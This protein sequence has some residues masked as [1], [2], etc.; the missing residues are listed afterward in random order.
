MHKVSKM[1]VFACVSAH[2]NCLFNS[3]RIDSSS[4]RE[5]WNWS[6]KLASVHG[7]NG[8]RLVHAK[9]EIILI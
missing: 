5:G 3:I 7:E 8:C 4:R 1:I 9:G 2:N 6:G